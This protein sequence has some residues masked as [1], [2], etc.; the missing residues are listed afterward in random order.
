MS[1]YPVL[2]EG[3]R[4]QALVVGG[5]AV[6]WRKAH[7]LLECGAHVRMVAPEVC[8]EARNAAVGY[9]R[10][11]IVG[12]PYVREDI[13]GALLVVAATNVRAINARVAADATR[14]R[15]LVNV[16]D[17][18]GEGHYVTVAAHRA[19]PL[20]VGVSTGAV[21]RA[22]ARIRDAI[23]VRFDSRYRAAVVALAAL[24]QR[25]LARDADEWQAAEAALID[26]NFCARVEDGTF[27]TWVAQWE[28]GSKAD[29]VH[30]S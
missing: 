6:A 24:R 5:G 13:S 12:R 4:I 16:V 19:D 27:G 14:L 30:A 3:T 11:E 17:A 25:L 20:V 26:E 8:A 1:G 9:P 23:A 7:A 2:L 15:R 29:S 18:P 21:P 22:A 28:T 10:L